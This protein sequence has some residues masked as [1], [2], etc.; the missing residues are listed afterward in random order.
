MGRQES[1][2]G[3]PVPEQGPK[4]LAVGERAMVSTSHPA[5]TEAMLRVLREGGN[6]VDAVLTAIPL[7]AVI[8][9][10][11]TTIAGGA[12]LLYYDAASRTYHYLNASQDHPVGRPPDAGKVE[13]TSG[14]R[15][16]VPGTVVGMQAA[17]ERFGSRPWA[18]YFAPAIQAAE[19]GFEVYSFLYGELATAYNRLVHHASGRE[20]YTPNGFLPRVDETWRQPKFAASL[21]RLAEP[22][23]VDW[24]QRGG[25]AE[26]WVAAV[27]ETGGTMTV[28]DMA[29]YE[30]RWLEPLRFRYRDHE[31]VSTTPPDVGGLYLGLALGILSHFDLTAMGL[32]T[33]NPKT[34]ALI[35][36]ALHTVDGQLYPYA[37]DPVSYDVPVDV[38]LAPEF[39]A[40][41]AR[42]LDGSW[43][44]VDLTPPKA[45]GNPPTPET[46]SPES[47]SRDPVKS[48]SNHLVVADQ[49]GNW[50]TMLHSVYGS[51]FGT[52]LVVEG[53]SVNSGNGFRG[54]GVGPGRRVVTPIMPALVARDGVPWLGIGTPSYPP[55]FVTQALLN[56]LDF[57]LDLNAAIAAPRYRLEA[58]AGPFGG[59]PPKLAIENR[60]PQST[61]DGLARLGIEVA[62]LG[63]YNWHVGS[64]QVVRRD[65]AT[66][67]LEGAADPRRGGWAGGI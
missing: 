4:P 18:S 67:R 32:P 23:G 30:A 52:G 10:Q 57:G 27:R 13:E 19:D 6:A 47:A 11:M 60:I 50:V 7:Q 40:L 8:E 17:A 12:V 34:L 20:H 48:D 53:I 38:L 14:K 39:A 45:D 22:D 33:E 15:I 35:A 51:T 25:F 42:L 63:G 64:V 58:E 46:G 54:V 5:V 44:R 66:G 28:Q 55:P 3:Q 16:A 29:G 24:F 2:P 61:V 26:K 36:R 21:R 49:H 37:Q 59:K 9:P 31:I 62:P 65:P 43:P 1:R 56:I 41:H